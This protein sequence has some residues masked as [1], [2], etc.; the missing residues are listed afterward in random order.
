M[1]TLP[2][3]ILL[4]LETEKREHEANIRSCEVE[5]LYSRTR[6]AQIDEILKNSGTT[7]V[8]WHRS[9]IECIRLSQE[10]LSTDDILKQTLGEESIELNDAVKRRKHV[11]ALSLVINR[12]CSKDKLGKKTIHG[13]Q[14][15]LY[16]LKEWENKDGFLH[17]EYQYKL[18]QKSFKIR[19]EKLKK[20]YGNKNHLRQQAVK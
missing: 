16:Y 11:L 20:E 9:A 19:A 14:G 7:Q 18:E 2:V 4:Q 6:I 8:D 13:V 1:N 3:E 15:H 12:L 5:I 10:P 17:H